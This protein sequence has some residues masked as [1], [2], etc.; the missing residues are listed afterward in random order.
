VEIRVKRKIRK[1]N[2]RLLVLRYTDL[3]MV[4]TLYDPICTTENHGPIISGCSDFYRYV[5]SASASFK[6]LTKCLNNT[7]NTKESTDGSN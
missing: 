2:I 4:G 7:A 6:T 3:A 1:K 5:A